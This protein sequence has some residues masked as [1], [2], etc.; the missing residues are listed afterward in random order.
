MIREIVI[1][2]KNFEYD[3]YGLAKAFYPKDEIKISVGDGGITVPHSVP[4]PEAKNEVKRALYEKL[5]KDTGRTLPWGTL[6]GIRP[7]K[8]ARRLV[9]EGETAE[10]IKAVMKD[11]YMVSDEK[12]S[13][14]AK[15]AKK[16]ADILYVRDGGLIRPGSYS[17]YI[18]IPFCPTTCLYCSFPSYAISA[19]EEKGRVELYLNALI[20]EIEATADL[21]AG[22]P[23]TTVYFGGGTP[24]SLSPAELD[25]LLS[26]VEKHF[27]LKNIHE[28]TVEA[29]RPDSITPDKLRV[30]RE[31]NVDRISI[32]PQTMKDET[33]R[34]IGRHT[35]SYDI[36]RAYAEAK[37]AGFPVINMDIILGLPGE[38]LSDVEQ[39]LS[40]IEK[41]EPDNL[42]VH[43]L[44]IKRSSRLNIEWDSYRDYLMENSE[45]HMD[46]A[47]RYAGS[48]RMEPYYLYRQQNM[49]GNLENVGFSV[50]GKDGLYNISII[51]EAEDIV[52]LGAGS[53]C[54]KII[55]GREMNVFNRPKAV[56]VER[57]ENVKDV[58]VYIDRIDEMIERKRE[59]YS[60]PDHLA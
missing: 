59:L 60:A 49:A 51:E 41:M 58:D 13:L 40:A 14:A 52:A 46:M 1:S 47:Y 5:C 43:S 4:R 8:I 30:L 25:R 26:A 42:T 6:S 32:N 48:M 57:C 54:K 27:P 7:V 50:E 53:A 56:K 22:R 17:L 29:G 37:E 36:E 19:Y 10:K 39:T 24:T 34:L 18:G 33:L 55:Y 3:L 28:Y 21:M 9:E 23:L 20:K 44:A 15:I 45:A 35:R 11:V 16:E 2:E 38:N 31:H 12:A